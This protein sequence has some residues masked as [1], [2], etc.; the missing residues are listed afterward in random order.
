MERDTHYLTPTKTPSV[1]VDLAS[2][3][4]SL[5]A[6]QKRLEREIEEQIKQ[7]KYDYDYVRQQI[8]VKASSINSE[9]KD[10]ASN[11]DESITQHYQQ[12]QRVY[13]DL[14]ADTNT[15][16]NELE[17]LRVQAGTNKQQL[18][19]NLE[20]IEF[21]IRKIREAVEHQKQSHR[22][23]TFSEGH[24]PVVP[25]TV[26]QVT[27]TQLETKRRYDST[28]PLP[29]ISTEHSST[30]I[31]PYKYVKIDHLSALEPESIAIT[32]NNKK[33]LLG[34]C[35]KLFILNDY[36]E[37]LKTIPLAPSIRG[38]TISKKYQTQNI[39][40]ISHGETVSMIDI[41][42]GQLLDCVKGMK[43]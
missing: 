43:N 2:R 14:A 29:L 13:A 10:I 4:N 33:I 9:I 3:T 6:D 37:L 34:I 28:P 36:G 31:V 5:I 1:P 24:H 12:Q 7:L 8:G 35:N 17:R 30:N 27:Y 21:S 32:D 18:L 41:D 42:N 26:G 39:A 11:L 38:I 20:K 15:I 40:Y 16:G 23:I 22:I 25:D 19:D